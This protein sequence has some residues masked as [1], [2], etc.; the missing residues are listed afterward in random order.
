LVGYLQKEK[1]DRLEAVE[2]FLKPSIPA[3]NRHLRR[4]LGADFYEQ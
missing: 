4:A 1:Q 2:Q 3:S